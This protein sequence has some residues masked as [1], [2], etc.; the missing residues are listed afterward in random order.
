MYST[1]KPV[2]IKNT[3]KVVG[4]GWLPSRP[5]LRDYTENS[6]DIKGKSLKLGLGSS[7]KLKKGL[8]K[9]ID[10]RKW[11]SPIESQGN[12]GS[13]T[14]HAAIGI[15]EYFQKRAFN[16]H[17]DG[18][19]LFVYKTTR[20]LMGATGDT[21]ADLRNA[22]GALVL[23]GVPPEQYWKYTDTE[24]DYDIEPS[25]FVYSVADNFEALKYFCHD[26]QS[27]NLKYAIVLANVKK[28][29]TAGIPSMFGFW[30]FD[31]F[32]YADDP[33]DIPFPCPREKVQWGH[34]I[35][36]VGYDDSK[37]ITNTICNE[38]TTGA[39]RIRNSWGEDWGDN[40]YGWIPYEYVL[41]GLADDFWS[42]LDMECVDTGKFGV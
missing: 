32:D 39:I 18:S 41:Q 5:D 37:K 31:S 14:A 9:K 20:N 26:P 25:P 33:A 28:F 30:G 42:L 17:I 24:P 35:V 12:I 3:G 27:L 21:G 1:Y 2:K 8:P 6:K 15:V 23:C 7:G 36:A 19:R 13:C 38:T 4:T 40:G 34:A 10:L 22:M 29:L 11:C 16:K